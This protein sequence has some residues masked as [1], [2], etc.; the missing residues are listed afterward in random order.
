MCCQSSV[1]HLPNTSTFNPVPQAVLTASHKII[2]L[3]LHNCNVAT[4]MNHNVKK[5]NVKWKVSVM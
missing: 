1:L 2:F 4:V 3:L 5:K